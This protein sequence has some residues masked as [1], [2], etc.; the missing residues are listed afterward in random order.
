[1]DTFTLDWGRSWTIRAFG[2][3]PLVRFSDRVEAVV[4][5]LVFATALAVIPVAGAIGTAVYESRARLYT[6][7]AQTRHTVAATAIEDSTIIVEQ[8]ADGVPRRRAL[9]CQWCRAFRLSRLRRTR[10]KPA[11][12]WMS[13]WTPAAI[14]SRRRRRHGGPASMRCSPEREHGS[15]RW[16][17]LPGCRCSCGGG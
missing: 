2:R 7:Q 4:L 8:D 10:P 3:N 11:T 1:M 5:V 6:E 17:A 13:G 12:N 14:R 16:P 15:S 9:A